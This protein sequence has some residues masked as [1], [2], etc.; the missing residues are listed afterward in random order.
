MGEPMRPVVRKSCFELSKRERDQFLDAIEALKAV[1]V[2]VTLPDGTQRTSNRY[3]QFVA[4]HLAISDRFRGPN[5]TPLRDG[6]HRGSG[7]LPWHREYLRR[8]EDALR[9]VAGAPDLALPYW[10]FFN[11]AKTERILFA[12]DFLGG[13]GSQQAGGLLPD[14]RWRHPDEG[15]RWSVD[16]ELHRQCVPDSHMVRMGADPSPRGEK[17]MRWPG[18]W[19]DD[20]GLQFEGFDDLPEPT[21]L[22]GLLASPTYPIFRAKLEGNRNHALVPPRMHDAVHAFCGGF[23][24]PNA[25]SPNSLGTMTGM[26]SPNDPLFWVLHTQVDRLWALWQECGHEGPAWYEGR[27]KDTYGHGLDE[28]MW[29]WDGGESW[30]LPQIDVYLPD[31]GVEVIT[32]RDVL[33]YPGRLYDYG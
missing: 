32:P 4:L 6:A 19:D 8:F 26:S 30:A 9:E 16:P 14:S 20:F 27:P 17:L 2:K 23:M 31:P 18:W 25:Q 11:H 33:N 21:E 1:P 15:G 3:D 28:P 12:G 10:D 13:R 29:P 7:F 22:P 24:R 5:S